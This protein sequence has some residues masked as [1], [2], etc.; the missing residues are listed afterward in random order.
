[1]SSF[2]LKD[3]LNFSPLYKTD[4][5]QEGENNLVCN[6]F[7]INKMRANLPKGDVV[8]INCS[9]SILHH[10]KDVLTEDHIII[11]LSFI[12]SKDGAT[13]ILSSYL[14]QHPCSVHR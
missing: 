4:G 7:E 11:Y 3:Q 14:N 1:M 12:A 2:N 9:H 8:C 13:C 6:D 5:C 10:H